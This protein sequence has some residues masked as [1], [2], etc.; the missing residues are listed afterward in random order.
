M[1]EDSKKRGDDNDKNRERAVEASRVKAGVMPG[2]M[3]NK[4]TEGRTT[5]H[6]CRSGWEYMREKCKEG[7]WKTES[8]YV[9][10][11]CTF[12]C[13]PPCLWTLHLLGF[14]VAEKRRLIL[15]T[16]RGDSCLASVVVLSLSSGLVYNRQ[17]IR[18]EIHWAWAHRNWLYYWLMS[19]VKS[20][21]WPKAPAVSLRSNLTELQKTGKIYQIAL[22][23]LQF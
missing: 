13:R 19:A 23:D 6:C 2:A 3:K 4:G 9:C 1:E 16:R 14:C 8:V 5:G 10:R 22:L 18:A 17:I 20:V 12:P 7:K 15:F 11:E 21:M